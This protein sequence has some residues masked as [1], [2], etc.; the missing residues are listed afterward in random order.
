MQLTL[1]IASG[2]VTLMIAMGRYFVGRVRQLETAT[3]QRYER[4]L[5]KTAEER[6][7]LKADNNKLSFKIHQLETVTAIVPELRSQLDEVRRELAEVRKRLE[8]S[9]RE[10]AEER[11]ELKRLEAENTKLTRHLNEARAALTSAQMQVQNYREALRLVGVERSEGRE[12]SEHE[13]AGEALGAPAAGEAAQD[14]QTE[15]T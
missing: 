13:R 5:R 2:I 7:L 12:T 9:E 3:Q 4:D 14:T 6:D 8:A 10:R 11:N 1:V 15:V